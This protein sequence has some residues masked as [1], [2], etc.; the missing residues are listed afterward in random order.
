MKSSIIERLLDQGHITI[1]IA[2]QILNNKLSKVEIISN[3]RHDGVVSIREAV[4]LLKDKEEGLFR[5]G[6]PNQTDPWIGPGT[7]PYQPYI[8]SSPINVPYCDWHTGIGNPVSF[9]TTTTSD[10][11]KNF[12]EK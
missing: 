11:N 10:L 2:D 4:A 5:L 6:T 7:T 1:Y 12:T 3:L 9:T 8:P